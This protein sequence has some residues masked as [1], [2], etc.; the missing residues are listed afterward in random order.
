MDGRIYFAYFGEKPLESHTTNMLE[1]VDVAVDGTLTISGP[2]I[3][4][5]FGQLRSH[6]QWEIGQI[7][8]LFARITA[9]GVNIPFNAYEYVRSADHSWF[10]FAAMDE[11]AK[12]EDH[13]KGRQGEVDVLLVRQQT[14]KDIDPEKLKGDPFKESYLVLFLERTTVDRTFRR[15]GMGHCS[16]ARISK[17]WRKIRSSSFRLLCLYY[18]YSF[19]PVPRH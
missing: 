8:K 4:L 2:M 12:E 14:R 3:R 10:R 13:K 17:S 11:D 1:D 5:E 9:N 16:C 19:Y 6:G 15:V 7:L 18:I